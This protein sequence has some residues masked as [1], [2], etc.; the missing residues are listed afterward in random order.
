MTKGRIAAAHERSSGIRQVAPVQCAPHLIHASVSQPEP[1]IKM[2]SQSVQPFSQLTTEGRRACPGM[3]FPLKLPVGIRQSGLPT[4]PNRWFIGSIRV[5]PHPKR[6]LDRFSRFC[7]AAEHGHINRIRQV[8][9]NVN[10]RLTHAYLAPPE[11][12]I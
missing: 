10:P 5:S 4:P 6:H 9:A 1:T 11:S 7:R 3:Y 8:A 2:A 12:T